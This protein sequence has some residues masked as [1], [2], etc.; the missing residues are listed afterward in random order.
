[1]GAFVVEFIQ[2]RS[3]P[4]RP[5]FLKSPKP[6][7]IEAVELEILKELEGLRL[8]SRVAPMLGLV[9]TMIPLGPALVRSAAG[10]EPSEIASGLTPAFSAVI[11]SLLAAAATFSIFTVRRRWL[12][13]EMNQL[14]Y[15]ALE[16][17][18]EQS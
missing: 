18:V 2:R 16:A 4:D 11:L 3:H 17:D 10:G 7:S 6:I 5:L 13:Q 12:L 1:M 8:C 14:V 15:G 9:A